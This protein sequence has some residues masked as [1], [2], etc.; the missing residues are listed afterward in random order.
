MAA[1]TRRNARETIWGLAALRVLTFS[2]LFG[3][4]LIAL[5]LGAWRV[6]FADDWA[7]LRIA[8]TFVRTGHIL[9]V[10]WNDVALVGELPLVRV[11]AVFGGGYARYRLV[12]FAA[13]VVIAWAHLRLQRAVLPAALALAATLLLLVWPGFATSVVTLMT[14][15]PALA[16]QLVSLVLAVGACNNR[17]SPRLRMVTAAAVSMWAVTVRQNAVAGV[18]TVLLL[19]LLWPHLRKTTIALIPILGASTV[20]FLSWR[21]SLANAGSVRV[22]PAVLGPTVDIATLVL[23]VGLVTSPL[24]VQVAM[25]RRGRRGLA[26]RTSAVVVLSFVA[27]V[28][29]MIHVS[30]REAFLGN[31]L[32]PYGPLASSV[33]SGA[34]PRLFPLIVWVPMVVVAA[35]TVVAGC[36]GLGQALRGHWPALLSIGRVRTSY[37]WMVQRPEITALLVSSTSSLGTLVGSA[38]LSPPIF[39][40]YALG[41]V[42][43]ASPLFI[44]TLRRFGLRSVRLPA[45]VGFAGLVLLTFA[46]VWDAQS[47]STARWRLAER[48]VAEKGD[49]G[50]LDAGFEWVGTHYGGIARPELLGTRTAFKGKKGDD[51]L[52]A[53]PEFRRSAV[54]SAVRSDSWRE[55]LLE[56][57]SYS[58]WFGLRGRP[59]YLYV[60]PTSS[61]LQLQQDWSCRR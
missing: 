32:N 54:V 52:A 11:A 14:D 58:Q 55:C 16:I 39:D 53:F 10:G 17:R 27:A 4:A 29:A 31:T 1:S 46:M 38:Y 47:F 22:S 23:L 12:T 13:V 20:G 26:P 51:Y 5:T 18:L 24:A 33:L 49:P 59:L 25:D 30:G 41:F 60:I 43:S 8:D 36:L 37:S 48:F 57:S 34:K 2:C 35:A 6:P 61:G 56:V 28:V 19:G 3:P 50:A 40:R 9:L 15:L 7:Y 44:L 21:S 45:V 42:A